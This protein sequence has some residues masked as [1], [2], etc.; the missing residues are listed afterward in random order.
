[1]ICLPSGDLKVTK[2]LK[3]HK[4]RTQKGRCTCRTLGRHREQTQGIKL[5]EQTRGIKTLGTRTIGNLVKIKNK[6]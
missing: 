3:C 4:G 1:M 6:P 5:R 2:G